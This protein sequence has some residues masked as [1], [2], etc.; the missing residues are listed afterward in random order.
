MRAQP[1]IESFLCMPSSAWAAR[2]M[3]SGA[4]LSLIGRRGYASVGLGC[5]SFGGQR[6]DSVGASRLLA[7]LVTCPNRLLPA[8]RVEVPSFA[9][10]IQTARSTPEVTVGV[11]FAGLCSARVTASG[12]RGNTGTSGP[13]LTGK[14]PM[15]EVSTRCHRFA[16]KPSPSLARLAVSR[17]CH[18]LAQ[19]GSPNHSVK[20]TS[21]GKPQAAPYVE[22]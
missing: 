5:P 16:P 15:R 12:Q 17:S 2:P 3:A 9:V 19:C 1:F 21:C 7:E 6:T 22:R 8:M 11:P 20:G 4:R 14:Y 18:R 13:G 10:R